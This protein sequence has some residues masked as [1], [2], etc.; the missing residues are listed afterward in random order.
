MFCQRALL[1]S[2]VMCTKEST[3]TFPSF[4]KKVTVYTEIYTNNCVGCMGKFH[5]F[6][7]CV[8]I[9]VQI[10]RHV[11]N[12]FPDSGSPPVTFEILFV[13]SE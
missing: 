5:I 7:C 1:F 11:L 3:T 4:T 12:G 8:L 10:K 9:W 13:F 6:S 2:A